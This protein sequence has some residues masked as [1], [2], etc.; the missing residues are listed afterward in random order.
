M[1]GLS[2]VTSLSSF[3]DNIRATSTAGGTRLQAGNTRRATIFK[4]SSSGTR[5]WREI[6]HIYRQMNNPERELSCSQL[7]NGE[8]AV[9]DWFWS[10]L[11]KGENLDVHPGKDGVANNIS[12]ILS[13][14]YNIILPS[15]LLPLESLLSFGWFGYILYYTLSL[16]N[17]IQGSTFHTMP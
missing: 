6:E 14:R 4:L 7:W 12:F 5:R 13:H 16:Q 3:R 15:S 8:T 11:L 1:S 17:I 2:S 10:N 9:N